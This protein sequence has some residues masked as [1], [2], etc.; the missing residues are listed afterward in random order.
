MAE[1]FA[2]ASP[3]IYAEAFGLSS[4]I[5]PSRADLIKSAPRGPHNSARRPHRGFVVVFRFTVV[6]ETVVFFRPIRRLVFLVTCFF[7]VVLPT[8]TREECRA[9]CRATF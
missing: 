9:R 8:V 6:A 3:K 5:T 2:F 4:G 7:T 1:A